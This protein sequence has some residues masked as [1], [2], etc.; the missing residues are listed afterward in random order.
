[1]ADKDFKVKNGIDVAGNANIAG[2]LNAAKYQNSAPSSP[3]NGQIWIDSNANTSV[4]NTNDFLLK[5]DA[6]ASSGYLLKT[7]AAS[8]YAT[9]IEGV[10]TFASAA[11]RSSA[12]TS[13]SEGM[14]SYLTDSNLMSI[15]DGSS[16]KPSLATAGGI[17]Q[18]VRT[19]TTNEVST[20]SS[21]YIDTSLTA[22]IT[23]K[24][25][26]SQI[27]VF[28]TQNGL[29]KSAGHPDNS[30]VMRLVF[31]NGTTEQFAAL[32]M[33]TGTSTRDIQSTSHTSIYSPNSLSPQTFKTQF[34]N[35]TA[36]AAVTVQMYAAMSTMVLMEVAT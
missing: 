7:D 33:L 22:T 36:N 24:S 6:S 30:F 15:Y 32:L 21:S 20:S 23:P 31:P 1:M 26:S 11:A 9:K 5:A 16:W 8:G 4:L 12:I 13:P 18:V 29:Q 14:V 17:L 34:Q 35:F 25:A 10:R 3:V 27:L 2:N 28:I 19:F